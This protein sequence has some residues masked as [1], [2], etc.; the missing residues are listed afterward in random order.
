MIGKIIG[1][2]ILILGALFCIC[3]C[4]I[5]HDIEDKLEEQE[6]KNEDL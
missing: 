6:N 5:S 4:M 3:T 1:I 2:I